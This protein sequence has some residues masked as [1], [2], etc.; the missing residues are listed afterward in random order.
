MATQPLIAEDV[1]AV[2]A[3]QESALLG[4]KRASV[5]ITGATGFFGTWLLETLLAANREFALGLRVIA[6]SRA[7]AQFAARSPCL[8]CDPAV[9]WLTG[10]IRDFAFPTTP[11]SHVIHAGAESTTNLNERDPQ[12]MFAVCVDGTRR[13]L[14][15]AEEK[16][17][18]RLLF[19]SSGAVYGQQPTDLSHIPETFLGGPDPLVRKNAYAEGKRAAEFLCGLAAADGRL[20]HATIARCFAFIGPHL[21]LDAHFAA[22]NFIR[23]A[24]VGRPISVRGDGTP[25]RSYLYAANLAEWLIAILLR[26]ES[27][28]AYNVGSDE[29][30]SIRAL[31][32]RVAAVAKEVWPGRPSCEVAVSLSPRPGDHPSRYVPCIAR[33]RNELGLEA[34]TSL[35]AAIRRTFLWHERSS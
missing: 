29:A 21:P 7:P 17:V 2:L 33:A 13:V 16:R 20:P 9:E 14:K 26:G 27:G 8:A 19:T 15:M 34:A 10:D 18:E 12:S 23:D 25:F 6:L 22:G 24:L 11:V 32:E 1:H 4:L 30:V 35:D 31:A 28:V 3:R 5:F